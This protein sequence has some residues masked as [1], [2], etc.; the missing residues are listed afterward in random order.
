MVTS[1]PVWV[2]DHRVGK[3][4][5][6]LAGVRKRSPDAENLDQ[7]TGGETEEEAQDRGRGLSAEP[8]ERHTGY[9]TLTSSI[10]PPL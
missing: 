10:T 6:E 3:F 4:T 7:H 9:Q 2:S 5:G 1:C 8:A